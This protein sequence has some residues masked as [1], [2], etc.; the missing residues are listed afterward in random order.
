MN[1]DNSI[2]RL[3]FGKLLVTLKPPRRFSTIEWCQKFRFIGEK[4]TTFGA[5]RFNP[6]L[7]PHMIYVYKCLDNPLMPE[8]YAM[9]SARIGWT[10]VMNNYRAKTIDTNPQNM[11]L[12]FPTKE[13]ART[14]A[15]GKW[16]ALLDSCPQ[17]RSKVNV[18][19]P[20]NRESI[21]DFFF[22]G[23]SLR[24]VT[25]GTPSSFKSDNISYIEAEECDDV[26]DN[27]KGQGD[28]WENLR[29][30]QKAV[31]MTMRK[32]IAGNT[33]TL[34]ECSRIEK[35][36]VESNGLVYK[37]ECHE[38]KGLVPLDGQAFKSIKYSVRSDGKVDKTYGVHDPL[39][40]RFYCPLCECEWS[41]EQ[42]NQNIVAG[43]KH[44][45]EGW[46]PT[47]PENTHIVGF[48]FSELLSP[49]PASNFVDLAKS[50]IKAEIELDKGN[51]N[52]MKSFVNN[53]MGLPYS[54]GFTAI[55][56][57]MMRSMRRNYKEGVIPPQAL[58]LTCGVD[59]QRNRFAIVVIGWGRNGNG[60]LIKWTEIFGDVLNPNDD[61]WTRLT[62]FCTQDF[63]LVVNDDKTMKI[64]AIAIDTGDGSTTENAY[65]WVTGMSD[66][67]PYTFATKGVKDLT[68]SS[69]EIYTEPSRAFSEAISNAR[70]SI[71]ETMGLVVYKVGAHRAIEETYRRINLLNN[72]LPDSEAH[73]RLYFCAT[74]YG[75][76]EEQMTS[77][78]KLPENGK[79]VYRL[80]AGKRKEALDCTKLALWCIYATGIRQYGEEHWNELDNY[81]KSS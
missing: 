35:L 47:R 61:V 59:I 26:K 78:K 3:F 51:E 52:P 8:I 73:D 53:R 20:K 15:K 12:G 30:R 81:Y 62:E 44:G 17:I 65:R 13:A 2:A 19:V 18:G 66:S 4:E 50:K 32:M 72:K 76:Y 42:K 10:E 22:M 69:N 56:A 33:P 43:L 48:Y 14:F 68:E 57:E 7:M 40:A 27:I 75:G 21:F 67:N 45:N 25:L 79:Y 80:I 23:G 24:L 37:A 38:C 16:Q 46:H 1:I 9:K 64:S 34:S 31:P 39:T 6:Y 11:L 28:I 54:S 74:E 63:P 29:E 49:F 5:G 77:V 41:F 71:A 36:M 60:Y 55:D 70:R 58:I